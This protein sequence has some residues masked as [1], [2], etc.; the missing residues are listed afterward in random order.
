[1]TLEPTTTSTTPE[2]DVEIS[3]GEVTG[4]E[5]FE[6]Q[7]GETV[8]ISV[9]A[10]AAYELHVHGYDL[11]YELEP[12]VLRTIE[13]TADVPGIFEVETHPGHLVLFEIEVAG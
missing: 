2:I 7:R 11:R 8:S 9:L 5:R 3:Q 1:M 13:F 10:D 12:G 6:Y 4:R